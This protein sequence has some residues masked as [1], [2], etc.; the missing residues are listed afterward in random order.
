[1]QRV[2]DFGASSDKL[3]CF[4]KPVPLM[5]NVMRKKAERL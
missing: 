1:M 4:F 2:R 5:L 3:D